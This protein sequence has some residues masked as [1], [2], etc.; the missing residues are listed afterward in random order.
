MSRSGLFGRLPFRFIVLVLSA[1]AGSAQTH[2]VPQVPATALHR[3]EISVSD[4]NGLAVNAA[5]VLLTASPQSSP[6]RCETDFAGH[7]TF[8]NLAEGDYQLR[9][10]KEGFYASVLPAVQAERTPNVDVVL[11]HQQE[12]REVVNVAESSP[13]L[14]PA[15]VS[16]KEEITGLEIID[17]PYPATHDY[18]NA[19]N[20]I[21]GVVQDS[22]GQPHV[23]GAETYQVLTLLD[24]FN[25]TQPAN[26]LLL[27]RVS[28]EAFRSIAVEPSREPAEYGKGPGG[29]LSLNTAIG[30]DHYHFLTT[31][32][33]PSL[34]DKKGIAFDQWTPRFNVSGP[35]RKGKIWFFDALEGEY[36]NFI[37]T[38]LPDTADS[39]Q[40]WRVGNLVKL[41]TNLTSRNNLTTSF[42][43]NYLDDQHSGLSP[44][45]PAPTTPR[46][47]E[48]AYVGSLKDQH[49]FPGGELLETGFNVDRYTLALTPLG[50]ESYF[51]TPET[52]G[53]NYYLNAHTYAR[54]WQALSNLYL[55]PR[56]WH[57]R[58]DLKAGVDLDRIDYD[59]QFSR[60]PISFLLEG[61]TLLPGETCF[62]A[63]PS[64]CSRYSEFSGGQYFTTYNSEASAYAEDRWL[65]TD[66]LLIEPGIRLDWDQIVRSP[67]L[68]PRLAGTYVL[69]NSGNTKLSAGIGI[70]YATT[71][72][73]LVAR[74]QAGQRQ[75]TFFVDSSGNPLATP[76]TVPTTFS[77]NKN[78]LQAPRFVNWSVALEKKLPRSVFLKLDFLQRR[79]ARDFV[80]NTANDL[81]GG[82][83]LLQH[84]RDDDYHAVQFS[85]RHSFHERYMLM[86]S[87]IRSSTHSNQ[88]L[89]FNVDSPILSPQQP[90][91]FLWDAPNR[92][93][94]W[95]FLPFFKLPV[96]HAL[97]LAYSTEARTG[98]PFYVS[99]DLQQLV[100]QPGSRRFPTYFTLNLHLEKRFHLFGYYW[101]LRGGFDNITNRPN[102]VV[103]NADINSPQFLTFSGYDRRGFTSRIRFLGKK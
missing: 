76:S 99:N 63:L 94:S 57:G 36:N 91:P 64:P 41:Q 29:V 52:S 98:F 86:G 61:K 35:I 71:S 78:T 22:S 85:L 27:V 32:F 44:L 33:I 100:E 5:L 69:D 93:L 24:G 30:D 37:V 4:E 46:D 26:G 82:N 84:T 25:V 9:V 17:I 10:E 43:Y 1:S 56:Y 20:F 2:R 87:Y 54:R 68:S 18:R 70:V 90:G 16:S 14:D 80:Y 60:R 103:V 12:L 75:D 8:A 92:F 40:F 53:G 73:V 89:D 51:I 23:A 34:Q 47:A 88:V 42:L 45:Q 28:P 6:V 101:A 58:H 83:F 66:R 65:L 96:I 48:S 11:H 7:C 79:G 15:Q 21:P 97:D 55:P 81:P 72:L 13:T 49:Y 39:D 59:A 95:G 19:L 62:T 3:L 102:P 50:T 31:N 77:V 38:Q 74:P 67:L